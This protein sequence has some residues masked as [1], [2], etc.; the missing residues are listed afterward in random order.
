MIK[1]SAPPYVWHPVTSVV[2][3][4]LSKK[5]IILKRCI[6]QNIYFGAARK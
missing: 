6:A 4:P 1:L 3:F 5:T 2:T